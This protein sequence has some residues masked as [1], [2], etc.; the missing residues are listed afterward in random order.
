MKRS[1]VEL[2]QTRFPTGS[3]F[4][5]VAK[6]IIFVDHKDCS[7]RQCL[8]RGIHDFTVYRKF[9]AVGTGSDRRANWSSEH[10]STVR[11]YTAGIT[12]L[13]DL[14]KSIGSC[15]CFVEN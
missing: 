13:L 8:L 11:L 3:R 6:K 1:L 7:W 14:N 5:Y 12:F 10:K 4:D 2:M 15:A 9:K